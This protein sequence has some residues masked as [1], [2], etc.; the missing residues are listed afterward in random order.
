MRKTMKFVISGV[1]LDDVSGE[2]AKKLLKETM[3]SQIVSSLPLHMR[4]EKRKE[5][6]D[7]YEDEDLDDSYEDLANLHA[8]KVAM[9]NLPDDLTKQSDGKKTKRKNK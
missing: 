3:E 2:F 4:Q 7:K 5:M 8:E 9:S 6:E 1:D